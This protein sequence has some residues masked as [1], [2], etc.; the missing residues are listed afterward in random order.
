MNEH[1]EHDSFYDE[2]YEDFANDIEEHHE[3]K[4][5]DDA[6]RVKDIQTEQRKP[7]YG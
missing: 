2:D 3:L 1:D 5:S 6:Q 4:R 7:Y